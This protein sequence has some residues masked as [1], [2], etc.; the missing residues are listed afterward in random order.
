MLGE[1]I[2]Q[3]REYL[4]TAAAKYANINLEDSKQQEE[5]I[6]LL[7]VGHLITIIQ[8]IN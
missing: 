8:N 3:N 6:L 2:K 1:F 5:K 4:Q 7:F